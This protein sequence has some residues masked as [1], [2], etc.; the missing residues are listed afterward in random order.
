M[1][2]AAPMTGSAPSPSSE[3]QRVRDT[4]DT[5]ELATADDAPLP[6]DILMG[7][8]RPTLSFALTVQPTYG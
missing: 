2:S 1:A 4:G 3:P 8:A 5:G 6:P 7:L